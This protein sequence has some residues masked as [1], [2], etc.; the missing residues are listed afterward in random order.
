MKKALILILICIL[1]TNSYSQYKFNIRIN[2]STLNGKKIDLYLLQNNEINII[3]KSVSIFENQTL[4]FEGILSQPSNVANLSLVYNGIPTFCR[5]VIDS[6]QHTFNLDLT[7]G[8]YAKLIISDLKTNSFNI[9]TQI[10]NLFHQQLNNYRRESG[11]SKA[12]VLPIVLNIRFH[13]EVIDYLTKSPNEY[14]SL[15]KLQQISKAAASVEWSKQILLAL[16]KFSPSLQRSSLGQQIYS[17]RNAQINALVNAKVGSKVHYFTVNDINQRQFTNRSLIGQNYLIVFSATWCIPCQYQLPQLKK[18][19][20]L[21]KADGLKVIYFNNDADVAKWKEHILKN[22]L[23]WINVSERLNPSL[24]KIQKSFGIYA[25]PTCILID[26]TGE[27]IYNSDQ[28]DTELKQL[29]PA[30]AKLVKNRL[31]KD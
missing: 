4:H 12:I 20:D 14:Y 10:Q 8:K 23:T 30:I 15:V 24:S 18:I 6:G 11:L 5:F 28:D 16:T 27:I 21:Y 9:D 2:T 19:Y 26:K 13:Q 3:K 22:E 1:N 31:S 7:Q 29:E 25:I 17:E